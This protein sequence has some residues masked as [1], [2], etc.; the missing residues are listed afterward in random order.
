MNK[1]SYAVIGFILG[2]IITFY[3]YTVEFFGKITSDKL[4]KVWKLL[5]E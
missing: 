3:L 4:K 1:W 2:I 5:N